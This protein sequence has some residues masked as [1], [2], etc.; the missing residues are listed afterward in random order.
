MRSG[1][2]RPS[3]QG[4]RPCPGLAAQEAPW[5]RTRRPQA[6]EPPHAAREL[7]SLLGGLGQTHSWRRMGKAGSWLTG[8]GFHSRL[9][10]P[11]G[12]WGDRG[13]PQVRGLTGPSMQDMARGH[14]RG[15][16]PPCPPPPSLSVSWG[17]QLSHT[18]VRQ[19]ALS[20]GPPA[21][22]VTPL[23][24]GPPPPPCHTEPAAGSPS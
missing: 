18:W 13:S 19:E 5:R 1:Q 14:F 8:P 6:Q 21:P 3:C 4:G 22:S 23:L 24:S 9:G 2:R 7:C 11:E 16:P 12:K 15:S 20:H 10:D 17:Q